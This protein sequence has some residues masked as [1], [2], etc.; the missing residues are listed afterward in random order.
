MPLK[1]LS[2]EQVHQVVHCATVLTEAFPDPAFGLKVGD[3]AD[4]QEAMDHL[5]S[6]E[7]RALTEVVRSLSEDARSELTALMW[8]GRGDSGDDFGKLVEEARKNF[9]PRGIE[10]I[11][12]KAPS[13]PV[14]LMRGLAALSTLS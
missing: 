14:Y 10:Y 11:T 7:A 4:F 5:S 6:P 3:R 9:G 12:Q 8:L 1:H 13:L 2:G